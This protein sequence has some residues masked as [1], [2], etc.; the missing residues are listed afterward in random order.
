MGDLSFGI[1]EY[2]NN[3]IVRESSAR[4]R[5]LS[6]EFDN[7]PRQQGLSLRPCN[8]I[9][10]ADRPCILYTLHLYFTLSP[11]FGRLSRGLIAWDQ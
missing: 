4:C 8:L 6:N 10:N 2:S 3:T 9:S 7:D 1:L 11:D 5:Q